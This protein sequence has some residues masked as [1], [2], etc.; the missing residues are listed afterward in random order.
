MLT[1]SGGVFTNQNMPEEEE[2]EHKEDENN[3]KEI[4]LEIKF[5]AW[6]SSLQ[7]KLYPYDIVSKKMLSEDAK[8]ILPSAHLHKIHKPPQV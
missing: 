5:M 2:E 4:K 6:L 7:P 8:L 1:K 3:P